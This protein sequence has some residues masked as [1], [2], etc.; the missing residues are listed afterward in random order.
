MTRFIS[1]QE[2]RQRFKVVNPLDLA[3]DEPLRDNDPFVEK[4]YGGA[5]RLSASTKKE[6][7]RTKEK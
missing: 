3:A 5:D 2:F 7:E 1:L 6:K 4:A